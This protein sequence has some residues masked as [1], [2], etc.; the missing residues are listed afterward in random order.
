[1][2]SNYL[3]PIFA[4]IL[5]GN[6][7]GTILHKRLADTNNRHLKLLLMYIVQL[8]LCFGWYLVALK[9]DD[10]H[11]DLLVVGALNGFGAFCMW[12]AFQISVSKTSVLM[13]ADDIVAIAL[14]V[15]FLGES[16]FLTLKVTLGILIVVIASVI[17][18]INKPEKNSSSGGWALIAWASGF[19]IPWGIVDFYFRYSNINGIHPSVFTLWYYAGSVTI[20]A[21]VALFSQRSRQKISKPR[22]SAYTLIFAVA[23]INVLTLALDYHAFEL[24]PIALVQPWLQ[25]GGIV[26]PTLVGLLWFKEI[27]KFTRRDS[28]IILLGLLGG[29]LISL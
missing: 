16:D 21:V 19:A 3:F 1:M 24:A 26:M 27:E 18:G 10:N 28:I 2:E 8:C 20:F 29:M 7:I 9:Q 15:L 17:Q 22:K 23:I 13:I 14:G 11:Y 5:L 25:I 12:R 6:G 4:R